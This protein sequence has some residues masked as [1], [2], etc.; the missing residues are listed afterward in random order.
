MC[1]PPP[2]R[3]EAIDDGMFARYSK[4]LP[5]LLRLTAAVEAVG[6]AAT[7]REPVMLAAVLDDRDGSLRR[8]LGPLQ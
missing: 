3:A 6:A 5:L 2:A 1:L 4:P 7:E 8:G